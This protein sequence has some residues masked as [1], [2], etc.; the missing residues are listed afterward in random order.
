VLQLVEGLRRAGFSEWTNHGSE[1]VLRTVLRF[2]RRAG[3]MAHDPFA[4]LSPDDLPRQQ[5]R[6]SFDARVLRPSEIRRLIAATT[7]PYRGV[8][9]LLASSGLRVSEAAGLVWEDVDLVERA[10]HV[11]KQLGPLRSGEEPQRVQLKSRASLRDVPL[12]VEAHEALLVQLAREQGKGLGAASDF[13]FTSETGRP[14]GRERIAKRGITR[15]AERAGL[16]HVTP[17]V[18]R[19]SVATLTAHARLPVVIAAAMTGHSPRVYD[20]HYAKPFRD[21]E[22]RN[23]IRESLASVGLGSVAVDQSVDQRAVS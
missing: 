18:L 5:A 9:T 22:E 6:E 15:A 21:A 3:Y 7:G 20:E 8:A 19:R 17:Q 10:I 11:R 23:R 12:L 4:A 1:T 2:A 14:L 16:G 13:V